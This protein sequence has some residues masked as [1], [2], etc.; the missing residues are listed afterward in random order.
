MISWDRIKRGLAKEELKKRLQRGEEIG[1]VGKHFVSIP[2]P[3]IDVP[4]FRHDPHGKPGV[5]Q[6][7]GEIGDPVGSGDPRDGEGGAGDAP[8]EHILEV[9]VPLEDAIDILRE[10]LEFPPMDPKKRKILTEKKEKYSSIARV[11][12]EGLRHTKR[13]YKEALRRQVM[14]G[15]YD[16]LN[17]NI[18]PVKPDKRY[19]SWKVVIERTMAGVI[20]YLMDVS[21]SMVDEMK[22]MARTASFWINTW[23]LS[24]YPLMDT[25]YIIHDAAARVVDAETFFHTRESGG[26]IISSAYKEIV[27]AIT[28]KQGVVYGTKR[29][30]FPAD[31][32]HIYVI[33]FS[34]GDNWSKNDT[35]NCLTILDRDILP[36]IDLFGYIQI[37][38]EYSRS[39][40]FKNDV[41][42]HF[43]K[44]GKW[45]EKVHTTEIAEREDIFDGIK[46]ILGK[47]KGV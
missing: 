11:G 38:G 14:L 1:K 24:E 10:A 31:E 32:Y 41:D 46:D 28:A 3:W 6:G 16:V 22:E 45:A 27:A 39:G 43:A 29:I 13:T 20:I 25:L 8:G 35:E 9:D 26:T 40:A 33:H 23:V 44:Y 47:R 36:F 15:D 19:K 18:V 17:P 30:S 4:T 7:K 37:K 21:G 2:I 34:D 5:G 42:N 12:P